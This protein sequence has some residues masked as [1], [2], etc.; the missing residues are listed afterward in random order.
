MPGEAF[1]A[2]FSLVSPILSSSRRR[3]VLIAIGSGM[4]LVIL[5]VAGG[6]GYWEW[7]TSVPPYQPALPPLPNPNGRDLA[8]RAL[9]APTP[10]VMTPAS[11]IGFPNLPPSQ[12]RPYLAPRRA[13]LD[14]VRASF[15]RPWRTR[16]PLSS[17]D[18]SF[19]RYAAFRECARCFVA[20]SL[21]AEDEGDGSLA[22]QRALDAVELGGRIPAGGPMLDRLVGQAIHAIGMSRVDQIYQ[23][24]SHESTAQALSR[25]RRIRKALPPLADTVE[26]ERI[27]SLVQATEL[28]R[29]MSREPLHRQLNSIR[30][31]QA[32]TGLLETLRA[33]FTPRRA[34]LAVIDQ[35]YQ[36]LGAEYRKPASQRAAV[37]EPGDPWAQ[38][39]VASTA[40]QPGPWSL[41]RAA[42]DLALLEV[43]LAV[44]AHR[45]E[46][47]R[48]PLRL[49]EIDRRLL[50]GVPADTAG[51]TIRYRLK[52]GQPV[53]YSVGPDGSDDDGLPINLLGQAPRP[54]MRGDVVLGKLYKKPGR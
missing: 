35:Y 21:V 23:S 19:Q 48:F 6:I 4:T 40:W 7:A 45:L 44:R 54:G 47:G 39:F 34:S 32:Q 3:G 5:L 46:R 28:F 13:R 1:S 10:R 30:D 22:L 37:A 38:V 14:A 52:E 17:M 16:P 36:L 29:S 11:F 50:P 8:S 33:A 25:V 51:N 18:T 43:G 41:D 49:K 12:L 42:T 2:P 53:V 15:R 20:E 27:T 26:N 24:A 9:A 31:Y